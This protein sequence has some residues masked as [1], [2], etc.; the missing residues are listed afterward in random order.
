MDKKNVD[1]S[2]VKKEFQKTE[3]FVWFSELSRE[4]YNLSQVKNVMEQ[5]TDEH[6]LFS[7]Q[8]QDFWN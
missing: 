7:A 4:I 3:A 6:N 8:K 2:N 1:S 5:T